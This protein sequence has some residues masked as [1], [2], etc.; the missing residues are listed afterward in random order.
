[1][2][3]KR[4]PNSYGWVM[5]AA[6]TYSLIVSNGLSTTGI[7]VFYKPLREE[8]VRM[9]WVDASFAESFIANAANITFIMSGVFSLAAG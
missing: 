5:V 8:F 1:M 2:T 4:R 3:E 9:G 6:A 7:P